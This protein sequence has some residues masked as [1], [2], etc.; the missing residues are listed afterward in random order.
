MG[1]EDALRAV[2]LL[3][4]QRVTPMRY[5]TLEIALPTMQM[6][7]VKQWGTQLFENA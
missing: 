3:P 4:P 1:P 6:H 5:N 7:F 2:E